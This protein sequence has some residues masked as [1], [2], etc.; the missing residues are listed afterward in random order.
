MPAPSSASQGGP[1]T[2]ETQAGPAFRRFDGADIWLGLTR[3]EQA[4]IGA[5]AI[6]LVA[7]WRLRQRVYEDQLSDILGR[8][9]EAAETLLTRMLTMEVSEALPD[10]ALEAEDGVTPRVPL[11]LGGICRDCG[12]TQEDACPGGCGWAGE[13]QCST[14]ARENAPA[15]GRIEL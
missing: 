4:R 3:E 2:T 1:M 8:A 12:C 13:D 11:L 14:C 6:E 7:S 5:V 15:A 10:G 9:A